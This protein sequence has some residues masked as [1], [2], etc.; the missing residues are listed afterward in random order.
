VTRQEIAVM[1]L[2]ALRLIGAP[3]AAGTDGTTFADQADI[4]DWA[5]EA[6]SQAAGLDITEGDE[7]GSF[8]PADPASRAEASVMLLRFMRHAGLSPW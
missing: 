4:P 2:R 6:V 7:T 1:L 5:A 8:R 3:L